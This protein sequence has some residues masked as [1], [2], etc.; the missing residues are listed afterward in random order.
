M[1]L[2]EEE[3]VQPVPDKQD[4]KQDTA[5][6]IGERN[7][8]GCWQDQ[9]GRWCFPVDMVGSK[10]RLTSMSKF[11]DDATDEQQMEM[12]KQMNDM[13]N[14]AKINLDDDKPAVK[15]TQ[16]DRAERYKRRLYEYAG[17]INMLIRHK[18]DLD[19]RLQGKDPAQER[20]KAV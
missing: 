6:P 2:S 17:L 3:E 11:A 13:A 18:Q 1:S 19:Y 8:G 15:E 20:I 7:M 9:T 14:A 4:T 10:M 16:H 5:V 12:A